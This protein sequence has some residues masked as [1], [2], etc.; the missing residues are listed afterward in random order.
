MSD[1]TTV[2]NK[3]NFQ[4]HPFHLVKP[5]PWPFLLAF[6]LCLCLIFTVLWL[7]EYNTSNCA[8]LKFLPFGFFFFFFSF[9]S[10]LW[11]V[12]I[13]ATFEGRHTFAVQKGL[14]MGFILFIVS[15]IMFFFG[16]FW[17]FFHSS[18]SP[19]IWIGAVWPPLGIQTINPWALPL[20]NTAIL[21]SSGVTVT[22][23]H[24]AIATKRVAATSTNTNAY[25]ARAEVIKGL[26]ATIALGLF[27]TSIQLFEYKH[28]G[29]S[30]N[31]GIYGSVFYLLTGF[32][33]FHV[34]VGTI[35][36]LICLLRHLAY[37]FT[38][39]HHLGLEMAIWYWHFVDIVWI[40]LFIFVY[41]WGA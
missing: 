19:A 2:Q 11:D 30:I 24:K 25:N 1:N 20:L 7:H 8:F 32:H 15:E 34:L 27:F 18:V 39:D 16:F 35:F 4:Q 5:S 28:A 26:A 22:W 21:L 33:G 10:W 13:E 23:A 40:F 6:S 12:V 41:V 3:I 37:H 38:R 9:I 29:F 17:A 36:L 31:D 14:R